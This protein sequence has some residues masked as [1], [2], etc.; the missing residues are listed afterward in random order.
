MGG[1]V[2]EESWLDHA[3]MAR[4]RRNLPSAS[5]I[6]ADPDVFAKKMLK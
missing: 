3:K 5:K 1:W 2:V 6:C 4:F